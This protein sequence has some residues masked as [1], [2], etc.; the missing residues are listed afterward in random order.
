MLCYAIRRP[1]V[2]TEDTSKLTNGEISP[3]TA[4]TTADMETDYRQPE[5]GGTQLER[6]DSTS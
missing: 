6:C 3:S 5:G 2:T 4:E 1:L